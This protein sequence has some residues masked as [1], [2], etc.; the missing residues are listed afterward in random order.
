MI[1]IK[2]CTCKGFKSIIRIKKVMY[3][4]YFAEINLNKIYT[5]MEKKIKIMTEKKRYL[6]LGG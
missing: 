3:T 2:N 1:L 6:P 4:Q 5:W